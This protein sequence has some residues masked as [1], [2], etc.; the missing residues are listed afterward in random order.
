MFI[1]F[2]FSKIAQNNIFDEK[3][4]S[5]IIK[6]YHRQAHNYRSQLTAYFDPHKFHPLSYVCFLLCQPFFY[7]LHFYFQI[8]KIKTAELRP[9]VIFTLNGNSR[10]F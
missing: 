9:Q 7:L 2:F 3:A 8:S 1:P 5:A 4:G 6:T 10:I